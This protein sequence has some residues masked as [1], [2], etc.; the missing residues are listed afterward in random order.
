MSVAAPPRPRDASR[1]APPL[2]SWSASLMALVR[3]GLRDRRR[4]TLIWGLSLGTYGGFMAAV[5]PSI[6]GSLDQMLAN[7]PSALKQAF[8]VTSMH[9]VEGYIQ[10]EMFSLIVPLALGYFV[11]HAITGP[12]VDAEDRG[13][14]DTTLSLPISRT[15]LMASACVVAAMTAAA[16]MAVTGLITFTVGRIAGT[17]IS[18][19]LVTAGVLGVLPLA[20]LAGGVAAV[21]AGALHRGRAAAGIALGTLIAMYAFDLAG[22]LAHSLDALRWLSAF[23]YYGSPMRDGIDPLSFAGMTVAAALLMAAGTLLLER[24]DVLH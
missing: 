8:D 10:T 5:Y 3:R 14:L 1:V 24:R 7:Y 16:V 19:G 15:V 18:P 9:T 20:L 6:Q 17:G 13:H 4:S 2:P 22:K 12:T 11:I 23:K 21:A